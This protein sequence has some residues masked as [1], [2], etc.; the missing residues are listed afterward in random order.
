MAESFTSRPIE[1]TESDE[2]LSESGRRGNETSTDHNASYDS[3]D[4]LPI[5]YKNPPKPRLTMCQILVINIPWFGLALMYLILAVEGL[6]QKLYKIMD[7]V[8]RILISGPLG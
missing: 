4:D 8:S 1:S 5:P 3:E 2:L 6:Y 7:S